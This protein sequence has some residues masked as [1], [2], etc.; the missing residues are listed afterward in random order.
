MELIELN[1][2]LQVFGKMTVERAQFELSITRTIRGRKV[3]RVSSG[4]LKESLYFQVLK[5][6]DNV[7]IEFGAAGAANRYAG[8]IHEGVNGRDVNVGSPFTFKNK[9][10]NLG[11]ARDMIENGKRPLRD[12]KTGRFLPKTEKNIQKAASAVAYSIASKGIVPVPFFELAS[13]WSVKKMKGQLS[14]SLA[15][16]MIKIL[17][18]EWQSH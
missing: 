13:A 14:A 17:T 5:R 6:R 16:D 4:A 15:K 2:T 1:K 12:F 9:F 7:R 10:I 8:Y 11:A 3:S 18:K